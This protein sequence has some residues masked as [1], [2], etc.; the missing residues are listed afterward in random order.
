[1]APFRSS[2]FQMFTSIVCAFCDSLFGTD[3]TISAHEILVLPY[4]Q[5]G[6]ISFP[7]LQLPTSFNIICHFPSDCG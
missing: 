4:Y 3:F 7:S 1:M 2:L 5:L 6:Q